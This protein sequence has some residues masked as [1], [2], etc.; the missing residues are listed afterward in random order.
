MVLSIILNGDVNYDAKSP[1]FTMNNKINLNMVLK[2]SCTINN[3]N[4]R[5][6]KANKS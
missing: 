1:W 4:T 2:K 3:V 6:C 5:V